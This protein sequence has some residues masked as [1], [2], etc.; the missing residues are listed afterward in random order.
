[1][2]FDGENAI[3]KTIPTIQIEWLG[4]RTVAC[5][6]IKLIFSIV[7]FNLNKRVLKKKIVG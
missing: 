4:Y 3:K 5:L 2:E 1:M 7:R 6:S